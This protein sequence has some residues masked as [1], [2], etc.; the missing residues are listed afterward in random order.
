MSRRAAVRDSQGQ[1]IEDITALDSDSPTQPS[2]FRP[3]LQSPPTQPSQP[4]GAR[5]GRQRCG[6]GGG[7]RR[8]GAWTNSQLREAMACV[9]GG[10]SMK[11]ASDM[12]HIPYS[13]F[14]E[15]C[16]G[17]RRT[18]KRGPAAVLSPSK[19]QQLVDYCIRMCELGLGL[20]PTALKLKVYDI[21][22]S[23]PTPFRN[24][25]PGQGWMRWWKR[26]HPEL[27]LR[28]AQALETARA[29]GLC[30]AN[31]KSFYDN[32]ESL[33]TLHNYSP[34]QIWNCDES[35][36]QA[37]RN[38]GGVVIA[39]R[40]ARHV[41]SIVPDQR[42]WLSVL[43]C[44][45]AGGLAIPSFYVFRGTRFRQNYIERCEPG[46]TM[47]MQPRAWMTTYL[48][49]A[50]L[51]HFIES[52]Q[53]HG[54]ISQERR[55]LLIL[56]GHNSHV[57]LDV[58]REARAAGL[59]IL[60]LPAHTSHAMQPLDVSI[61]KPFKL[62]F[63]AYRDYWTSRNMSQPANKTTL[64]QWVSLGLRKALTSSNIVSGFRGTGIWP[65][66]P[67]AMNRH[68]TPSEIFCEPN[69]AEAGDEMEGGRS[70]TEQPGSEP[71]RMGDFDVPLEA[72][73]SMSMEAEFGEVPDSTAAHFFVAPDQSDEDVANELAR[74]E[75]DEGEPESITRF[76]TL[77][78]ITARANPRRR[79]P[80]LDFTQS[81]ILTSD[82]YAAAVERQKEAKE[83]A[84]REKER[85]REEKEAAK[86]RK[87]L[88]KEAR[89]LEAAAARE[90]R[91]AE[92]EL[93]LRMRTERAA[94]VAA[95]RAA[96]A[97]EKARLAAE[98][99]GPRR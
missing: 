39:R 60:T 53:R 89:A 85:L 2:A 9:D 69:I 13:T 98:R 8:E 3:V 62:H 18:R 77:P 33:C 91:S 99:V 78:T 95:A 58:V 59:D 28:V 72:G 6:S 31:I 64:A 90:R 54:G 1:S 34:D 45:N 43:V 5:E 20:T 51:S 65:I 61:L 21:T 30:A 50:W 92:K 25:I 27:T 63:R 47:A 14:R 26:R 84:A 41:H 97:A 42:E 83:S 11:K 88:E 22:K 19:E 82:E 38:G 17:I 81:K 36:A 70:P 86:R 32:L 76:L 12:Y 49:S 48:F 75:L 15:W 37:G 55:H 56:D 52:V 23:R 96:K 44:I 73:S 67:A 94:Q 57:T 24:G 68:L 40:G 74:L 16:Y 35:G 29:R 87:A 71:D 79:D 46:A 93:A 66:N 80:I 7:T 4:R 10:M